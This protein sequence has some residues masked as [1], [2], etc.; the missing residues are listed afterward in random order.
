MD[1]YS[2]PG[3]NVETIVGN[4]RLIARVRAGSAEFVFAGPAAGFHLTADGVA[5]DQQT[6]DTF[7]RPGQSAYTL[8]DRAT[9]TY[10]AQ[11]DA[12]LT[13]VLV[14]ASSW[15]TAAEWALDPCCAR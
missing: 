9:V 15:G 7:V 5:V 10:A 12:L 13:V 11:P 3:Q 4:G 8:P 2:F 6:V 1:G 14:E